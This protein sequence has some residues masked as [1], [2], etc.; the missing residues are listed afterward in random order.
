M[1]ALEQRR[2]Y[3]E[4]ADLL[5]AERKRLLETITEVN[6]IIATLVGAADSLLTTMADESPTEKSRQF[7][8]TATNPTAEQ[9]ADHVNPGRK[10]SLCEQPGHNARTCPNGR[11]RAS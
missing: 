1:N 6:K 7:V 4:A 11:K 8:Y 2:I 3:Q 10:C 9:I 5:T